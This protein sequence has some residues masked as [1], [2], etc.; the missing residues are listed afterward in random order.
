MF[1]NINTLQPVPE[2]TQV[3]I[4]YDKVDQ[5]F[6]AD[7]IAP[8]IPVNKDSFLYTKWGRESLKD[9]DRTERAIG[10]GANEVSK[11]S[12][13][14]PTGK[15]VRQA[16][17]DKIADEI[18][19]TVA[20]GALYKAKRVKSIVRKL[21]V[22]VEV[23]VKAL[24]DAA[25]ATSAAG[26]G[27]GSGGAWDTVTNFVE[28][29]FDFVKQAMRITLGVE[30]NTVIFNK[31][32]ANAIRQNTTV[33]DMVKFTGGMDWLRTGELPKEFLGLNV[34]LP[35]VLR[36]GAAPGAAAAVIADI[37]NTK[38]AYFLYLDPES[39]VD[40]MTALLQFRN[41]VESVPY[42]IK[43]WRDPDQ[44]ANLTWFSSEVAQTELNVTPEALYTLTAVIS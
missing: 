22:G 11:I 6:V 33:R 20:N 41:T 32:V 15:V 37:W 34:I 27:T 42:A 12:L 31:Y 28:K 36:D 44:S 21:K 4:D 29:D 30:P 5:G 7:R 14:Y 39:S 35:G 18:L 16:L 3:A 43:E 10:V 17:K 25:A 26:A 23:R 24:L 8:V 2:L 13:T 1:E 40:T 38:S 19:N 9:I